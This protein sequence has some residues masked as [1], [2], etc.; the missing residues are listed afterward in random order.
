VNYK[1]NREHLSCRS[2]STRGDAARGQGDALLNNK[3][4]AEELM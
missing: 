4:E 2:I 3:V 1:K